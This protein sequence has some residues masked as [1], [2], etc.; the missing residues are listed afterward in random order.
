MEQSARRGVNRVDLIAGGA[1]LAVC[2]AFVA[3]AWG[4]GIGTPARMGRGFF[5]FSFGIAGM[6][7][8]LLI[9]ARSL[10]VPGGLQKTLHMRPVIFVAASVVAFGLL[11]ETAGLGPAVFATTL[12]SSFAD[13][14]ARLTGSIALGLGLTAGI[15][16]VF[17]YLLG[18]QIPLVQGLL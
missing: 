7:L 12:L 14:E 4:Y 9:M 17:V 1:M 8:A 6:V 5:P 11:I 13:S 2:A 10:I 3:V 16:V 15:W 18:L